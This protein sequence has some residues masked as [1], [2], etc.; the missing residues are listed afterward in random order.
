MQFFEPPTQTIIIA[1]FLH[2]KCKHERQTLARFL[3][4]E[5]GALL[6]R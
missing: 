1:E 3:I 2:E 4:S 5:N 6:A